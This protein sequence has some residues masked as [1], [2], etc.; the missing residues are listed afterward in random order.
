MHTVSMVRIPSSRAMI[1][2]GTRPPRVIATTAFQ[3]G[4]SLPGPA[5]RQAALASLSAAKQGKY[6]RFHDQMFD[7]GRRVS[8]D[9]VFDLV[10]SAGLNE[11]TT[12]RDM[13]TKALEDEI[14]RNLQL[15]RALGVSGTPAY[16]IGNRIVDG[17][18]GYDTLK[19]AIAEAR[20]AG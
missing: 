14:D 15:G 18:A 12:A 17:A 1:A 5:S 16:V 6:R 13:K 9:K 19:A 10:R 20:E 3:R 2:A 7:D 8:Q 4:A 11:V